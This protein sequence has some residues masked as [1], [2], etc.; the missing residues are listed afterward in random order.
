MKEDGV[1]GWRREVSV[2][3]GTNVCAEN[4]KVYIVQ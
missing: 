2:T 4:W 3:F 1:G